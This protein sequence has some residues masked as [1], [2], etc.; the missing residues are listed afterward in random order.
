MLF[1]DETAVKVNEAPTHTLTAE[2]EE[3][4]VVVVDTS[5]YAAR[6]DF[7]GVVSKNK[8][9]IPVIYSPQDRKRVGV[10]GV[11]TEML[12][13]YILS[14]LG[15][16]TAAM[17]IPPLTLVLD[18]APIHIRDRIAAAFNER[19][20]HVQQIL[21]LPPMGAKRMSPL[22]NALFHSWKE[23]IRQFSPL[24]KQNIE[25]VMQDQWTKIE[26]KSIKAHYHH[27]GLLPRQ[28]VYFDCPC[29]CD[30]KHQTKKYV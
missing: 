21:Y 15:Q 12:V 1:L 14:T 4:I 5:S 29:P 26:P 24:T 27:C 9:F 16:E 17:D 28:G 18:N 3:P 19:G 30:H 8:A 11:T 10:K 25:Q 20:G 13:D 22:D 2:G 23:R 6:Y 7:I